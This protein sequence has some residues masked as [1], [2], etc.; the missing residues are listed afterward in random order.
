MEKKQNLL[1]AF[2]I[3]IIL[4]II[5]TCIFLPLSNKN[6]AENT[7]NAEENKPNNQNENKT[8]N[9]IVV[10]NTNY[11]TFPKKANNYM[12]NSKIINIGGTNNDEFLKEFVIDKEIIIVA[13]TNSNNLDF[14]TNNENIAICNLDKDL[15]L[16]YTKIL[17]KTD[18][19]KY[20]DSTIFEDGLLLVVQLEKNCKI[21]QYDNNYNLVNEKTIPYCSNTKIV[22]CVSS[23]KLISTNKNELVYYTFSK[24]LDIENTYKIT[25]KFDTIFDKI[26][27]LENGEVFITKNDNYF[28]IYKSELNVENDR[29][30]YVINE[31]ETINCRLCNI[32]PN[33]QNGN[34][35]IFYGVLEN[36]PYIYCYNFTT[37]KATKKTINL[38]AKSY[39]IK[40]LENG[41]ILH[42]FDNNN[43]FILDK[44]FTIVL[45]DISINSDMKTTYSYQNSFRK[46]YIFCEENTST[47]RTVFSVLNENLSKKEI[48]SIPEKARKIDIK[49]QKDAKF[50]FINTENNIDEFSNLYGGYDIYII[51]LQE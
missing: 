40:P 37:N 15:N 16:L 20:L 27:K 33:M 9:E 4:A 23:F 22:N 12:T 21:L 38:T 36:K 28:T 25:I 14:R 41:Y 24:N 2:Y 50:I 30:Y 45:S 6:T 49:N 19:C 18:N 51:K 42:N 35:L 7:V 32:M 46:E 47:N 1:K 17:E 11:T 29:I 5:L 26:I 10:D 34:E 39:D 48:F 44:N 3:L 43:L 13:K 8:E 31:I